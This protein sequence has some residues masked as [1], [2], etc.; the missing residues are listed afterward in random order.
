M[1]FLSAAAIVIPYRRRALW[2]AS[3]GASKVFGIPTLTIGG[4]L[5]FVGSTF[6]IYLF[7]NFR[8]FGIP[9]GVRALEYV[10][11][12]V[13]IGAVLYTVAK[14][15]R[16][17][18]SSLDPELPGDHPPEWAGRALKEMDPAKCPGRV[19]WRCQARLYE[20]VR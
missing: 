6:I 12:T 3:P 4:V 11:L 20:R 18:A 5:A 19:R 1:L 17:R 14:A 13:V 2:A 15:I 16:G 7:D 8:Q 9:S 10:V